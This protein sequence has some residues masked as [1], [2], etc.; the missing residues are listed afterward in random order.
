VVKRLNPILQKRSPDTAKKR[1][2]HS[3]ARASDVPLLNI[4]GDHAC[5][6]PISVIDIGSNSV[7]LVTYEYLARSP[8]PIFNEKALCGL[9][10]G[11]SDTGKLD[12]EAIA[13][14]IAVLRRFKAI[15]DQ[16]GAKGLL[17]VATAAVREASNGESF[18]AR[19]AEICGS[20]PIVLSGQ[21]EALYS[22]YGILAGFHD[23]DGVMGDM[24]G[25]SVEI[26]DIRNASIGKGATFALGGLRLQERSGDKPVRAAVLAGKALSGNKILKAG[27]ARTFY[28]IGG[29]WR[30]LAYLHMHQNNYPLR[31]L[32]HYAVPAKK[33]AAF[34]EMII[35]SELTAIEKIEMISKSRAPLL[36][37]GAAVLLK[38]IEHMKP[39]QIVISALG[40][41]EGLLYAQ[42]NDEERAQDGLIAGAEILSS[43]RARSPENA[44]ELFQWSGSLFVAAGFSETPAQTRLRKAACLLADVGWRAHPDYR[45]E[46]S[47]NTIAH[48]ALVG[49][50][51]PGRA[52]IALA[53][54]FRHE[55]QGND[56]NLPELAN[57][58]ADEEMY[59]RARL[60]GFAFRTAHL[61]SASMAGTLLKSEF[62]R[63]EDTLVL[64]IS[65]DL[66][67]H[68]GERMMRRLNQISKL[69]NR[70]VEVQLVD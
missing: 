54:Y 27:K 49:I 56:K 4:S 14:A 33:M 40:V 18:M 30:S 57:L 37:Y 20:E 62:T 61:I 42:L 59:L 28:A 43:L 66:A 22:G 32:H 15:S 23:A 60:L 26:A 36:H 38:I 50:D 31:V 2:D 1:G 63:R 55:G 29:T 16:L 68:V 65:H 45:G 34:C 47:L 70:K 24:G 25:G 39:S 19:V 48:A 17:M 44:R 46:Q 41:R 69:I 21:D 10:S 67:A 35:N 64:A 51:H 5:Y 3:H 52:F 7:R 12:D 8:V 53:V 9:G 6:G 58:I 11:L 13:A